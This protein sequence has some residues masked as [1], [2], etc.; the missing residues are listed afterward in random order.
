MIFQ[1]PGLLAA[2]RR[3]QT[4]RGEGDLEQDIARK[5]GKGLEQFKLLPEIY[6][7]MKCHCIY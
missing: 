3:A 5:K 7:I 6:V 1:E 4:I 2:P